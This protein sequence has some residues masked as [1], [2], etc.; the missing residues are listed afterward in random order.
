MQLSENHV[1]L[2]AGCNLGGITTCQGVMFTVA[3]KRNPYFYSTSES[4]RKSR[5]IY[6]RCGNDSH[7]RSYDGRSA[8]GRN[9][10][11]EVSPAVVS[12][13]SLRF[14]AADRVPA[15]DRRASSAGHEVIGSRR[16][17]GS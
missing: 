10:E 8:R 12:L 9:G 14:E 17:G 13:Q 6:V 16:G 15:F 11:G 3:P 5:K 7:T 4:D 2:P 1:N